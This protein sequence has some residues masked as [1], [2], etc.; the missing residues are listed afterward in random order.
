[1]AEK[2]TDDLDRLSYA[3][4]MNMGEHVATLPMH[5][6]PHLVLS[7]FTDFLTSKPLLTP[8]EYGLAMR[9]LQE[10]LQE[11]AKKHAS[12]AAEK[13]AAAEKE[14]LAANKAKAGVRETA[15]GL[16]YEVLSE[17]KGAKP[18]SSSAKVR[19]HYTGKLLDGQVFDSSVQRG[20]PAE[21]GLN[22]VIPGWTEGLQLM[23]EGSKFRFYIPSRLAYGQRGAPG[24]IPPNAALIFDVELIKI[25]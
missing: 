17:G 6:N 1:M 24:A 9:E 10:K 18:A 5:V 13:N 14:F 21:F 25:L 4:G 20:E 2:F 22:Q 19:V 23:K 16:Q 7:G 12:Q 15:S 3:L 8:D 11:A